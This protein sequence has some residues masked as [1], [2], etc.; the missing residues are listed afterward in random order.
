MR[1]KGRSARAR[2][3]SVRRRRRNSHRR[4]QQPARSGAQGRGPVGPREP[5]LMLAL[6][7]AMQ[8]CIYACLPACHCQR[9]VVPR[10]HASCM[11]ARALMPPVKPGRLAAPTAAV[12]CLGTAV[13]GVGKAC[14]QL[15]FPLAGSS[16]TART[17][18]SPFSSWPV[19][20]F[21]GSAVESACLTMAWLPLCRGQS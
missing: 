16:G 21:G 19:R 2:D 14:M 17:F 3:A 18:A 5:P 8:P 7:T 6:P 20:G 1:C 15:F 9:D 10:A 13:V 11:H 4:P 12:C